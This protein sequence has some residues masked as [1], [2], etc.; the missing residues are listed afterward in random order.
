MYR[1]A[2]IRAYDLMTEVMITASVRTYDDLGINE[3]ASEIRWQTTIDGVGEP[4]S[5]EWLRDL[6][7][8]LLEDL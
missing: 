8:G 4:D 3:A 5:T 2:S 7:V 6:L 1:V